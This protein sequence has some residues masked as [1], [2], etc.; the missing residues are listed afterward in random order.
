MI[1]VDAYHDLIRQNLIVAWTQTAA[2]AA[3]AVAVAVGIVAV[4]EPRKAT[5]RIV[6]VIGNV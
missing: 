4:D 2:A 1:K 6:A 5:K 3:A